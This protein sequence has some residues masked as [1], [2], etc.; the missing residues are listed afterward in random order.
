MVSKTQTA[1]EIM[2]GT[3]PWFSVEL[4]YQQQINTL[5]HSTAYVQTIWTRLDFNEA[6]K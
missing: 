4:T 5:G 2:D 1:Q 6:A 3:Q